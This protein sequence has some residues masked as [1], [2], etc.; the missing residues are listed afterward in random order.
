MKFAAEA[1]ILVQAVEVK[2]SKPLPSNGKAVAIFG[3]S[4]A[5]TQFTLPVASTQSACAEELARVGWLTIGHLATND[6]A[7]Q[8]A[9]SSHLTPNMPCLVSH[10]STGT[11]DA[12]NMPF[13]AVV[14]T[15]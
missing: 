1:T 9:N 4:T 2:G 12:P 13:C 11:A 3:N 5:E 8:V 14:Q 15:T 10:L 6:F 7:V